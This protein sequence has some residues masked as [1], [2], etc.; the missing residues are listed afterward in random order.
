[1]EAA[2]VVGMSYFL[3]MRRIILPQAIRRMVPPLVNS[4]A[5]LLKYTS[6]ASVIAVTELLHAATDV[7]QVTFRPLEV[8]SFAA[9][10]YL[11][12]ILPITWLSRFLETR[13][14]YA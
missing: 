6:L 10:L 11:A 5:N 4:F 2:R 13:T 14:R 9:L 3:A 8:Y 12:L 7:I 1:M